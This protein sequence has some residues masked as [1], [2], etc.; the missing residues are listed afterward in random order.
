[1]RY[2]R[3]FSH[4]LAFTFLIFRLVAFFS[5]APIALADTQI[6][7]SNNQEVTAIATVAYQPVEFLT[8]TN[9][10]RQEKGKPALRLNDQLDAAA[11]TKA[12]DMAQKG[13]WDHFRPGDGKAPWDFIKEAGYSYTVAG[14]NLARGFK[15][16]TGITT[17]WLASPA[18]R[19]NLLSSKYGEVG[20]ACI[21]I[22]DQ[23]GNT[24]LLTVQM[25][26]SR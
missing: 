19:A 16:P 8:L 25:F 11:Y 13:Y 18:H 21:Q 22:K 3:A 7:P 2:V 20:F 26:G 23:D 12:M 24:L 5:G 14:E 10:A 9:Q 1:M 15:T 4:Q 6:V 17:A